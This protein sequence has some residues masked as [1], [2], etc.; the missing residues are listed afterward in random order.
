MAPLELVVSV[1]RDH[2][3]REPEL[4]LR[5][6]EHRERIVAEA[7]ARSCVEDDPCYG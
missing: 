4:A 6:P 7:A 5:S 2:L 1:D 3:E